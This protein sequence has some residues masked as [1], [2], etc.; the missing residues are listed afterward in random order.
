[1]LRFHIPMTRLRIRSC[2]VGLRRCMKINKSVCCFMFPPP[3][4]PP[5]KEEGDV[6]FELQAP[7][8]S[9][10]KG[11]GGMEEKQTKHSLAIR[12]TMTT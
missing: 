5:P 12:A 7:F 1:M 4:T 3:L 2:I 6:C 9:W 11:A 10:R 8:L